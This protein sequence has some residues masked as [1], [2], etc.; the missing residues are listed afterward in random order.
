[1]FVRY[2]GAVSETDSSPTSVSL[3]YN[4]NA[5]GNINTQLPEVIDSGC[6]KRISFTPVNVETY[7]LGIFY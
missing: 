3:L 6:I 2:L 4:L 5:K 1:M 7:F